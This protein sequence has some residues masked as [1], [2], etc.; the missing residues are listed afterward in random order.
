MT[1]Q[2]TRPTDAFGL[3]AIDLYRDIHKAIRAELFRVTSEA[4]RL[5]PSSRAGRVALVGE[6][7]ALAAL[8]ES[9]AAHEDEHIEGALRLHLPEL[10]EQVDDDHHR[11]HGRVD[12]FVDMAEAAADAPK[13]EVRGRSH[14]LYLELASFTST[15]L[16]HQ[17]LEERVVM[18][19]LEQA[20]G[21]DAVGTINGAI[22]ADIPPDEMA[23]SLAVMLPAMNVDDRVEMLSGMR[24]GAP[25]EVFE[26]VWGLAASVLSPQD[27]AQLCARLGIG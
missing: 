7:H 23:A 21:V 1:M 17:D 13:A 26:G 8:L 10:A 18:P 6:V 2:E 15:Y 27:H 24:A 5:D 3:V 25:P 14:L 22:V 20:I 9:H 4:G 11:L 12:R 19:A 16:E